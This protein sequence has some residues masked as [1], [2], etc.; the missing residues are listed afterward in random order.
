MQDQ[1][2]LLREAYDHV[3]QTEVP[4]LTAEETGIAVDAVNTLVR[5]QRPTAWASSDEPR[6]L[7]GISSDKERVAYGEVSSLGFYH[8]LPYDVLYHRVKR[9]VN[10]A[11]V[12]CDQNRR[13]SA[14]L[15][16]ADRERFQ[17]VRTLLDDLI[18]L[19]IE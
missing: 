8:A 19:R 16:R 18:D 9:M 11:G 14:A 6:V 13:S 5:L 1:Y 15:R 4:T 17:R 3:L 7:L 10:K 12:T 2:D